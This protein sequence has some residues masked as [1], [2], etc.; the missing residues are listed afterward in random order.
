[1]FSDTAS[2]S[3]LIEESPPMPGPALRLGLLL[4]SYEVPAWS[5]RALLPI[6]GCDYADFSLVVIRNTAT[7]PNSSWQSFLDSAN[8]FTYSIYNL[9]DSSIHRPTPDPFA[10]V[11]LR[12][13]LRDVPALHVTPYTVGGYEQ[14]MPRDIEAIGKH[15]PDILVKLGFG[16][17]EGAILTTAKYGVWAYHHGDIRINRDGP[18]GFWEVV[19]RWPETGFA[20]YIA[21]EKQGVP[22][23][24]YR[25]SS[26]THPYSPA[27][28]RRYC[29]WA[30]APLLSRQIKLLHHLGEEKFRS[31][32]GTYNK[33]LQFNDHPT[34]GCP[35]NALAVRAVSKLLFRQLV[36]GLVKAV[37]LDQ[38]KLMFEWDSEI[39]LSIGRF[40]SLFPPKDRFWADPC[41]IQAGGNYYIFVEEYLYRQ[42]RGRIAVI[43][44]D[45]KGCCSESAVVLERDY[46]LS[47]P[48][49]FGWK[50]K[51]YMVPESSERKTI[52]LYECTEF[53]H[54]WE[55]K[56]RLMEDVS[57]VDTTL[58]HNGGKWWLFTGMAENEGALPLVELFLFHSN[59]L[60]TNEWSPHALNPIVSDVRRARPAG[61]I[62]RQ[63]G[64]LFRPSQDCSK[65]YG[66]GFDLNEIVLLS[67]SNYEEKEV[68][69]VRPNWDRRVKATH[70]YSSEGGLTV[71]DALIRR[72]RVL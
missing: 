34:Y 55:V 42:K 65:V 4:D 36:R 51:Y 39:A 45:N 20:L 48:F 23:I 2:S 66:Y 11:D 24:L 40:K 31:A 29:F 72:S 30:S 16:Q 15:K 56:C 61:R 67:E 12:H 18:P 50:G 21:S 46:H 53:P 38:W 57:A 5:Y 28:N 54:R 64:R 70:T 13:F 25:S 35:T 14:L 22:T 32:V 49:V 41:V 52:D 58:I 26:F 68:I 17:L 37:C 62:F 63:R 27:G 44:M 59:D 19:E 7:V 1:M 33:P 10:P 60:V 43:V 9:I 71:I 3:S 8:H 69:S 6:A 47:Y